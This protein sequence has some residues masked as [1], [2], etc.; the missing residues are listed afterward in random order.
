MTPDPWAELVE[1]AERELALVRA[2]RWDEAATLGERRLR[3]ALAL[4]VPPASARP[5]LERLSELQREI[6]AGLSAGRA[7]TL[8]RLGELQRGGVALR[9]YGGGRPAA[10]AVDGRA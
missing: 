10:S 5:Q 7:F 2:E 4:D 3:A 1:L 6:H 8:R 9:G